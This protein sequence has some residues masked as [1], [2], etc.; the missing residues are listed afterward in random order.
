VLREY[1]TWVVGYGAMDPRGF[2]RLARIARRV[3]RTLA[4]LDAEVVRS[5]EPVAFDELDRREFRPIRPGQPFGRTLECAWLRITGEVPADAPADAVLLLG[6]RGEGLVHD[7]RGTV[8]DAVSTVFQQGDL[9]HSGGRFRPVR[10][11]P[12]EGRIELYADV[13]Y[14]GWLLYPWGRGVFHGAR[15]AVRDDEVF[16]LYYDYLTLLVLAGATDDGALRRE[17]RTALD[18]AWRRFARGDAVAARAELAGPLAARS[19]SDLTYSAIG[20]GHLDM[21]WLWPLRETRRKAAR[22]YARQLNNVAERPGFVYGTSQPQQLAWMKAEQ[23]AIYERLRAAVRDRRIELQ[24]SFWVESDT[25]LPGGEALVRQALVGRRFLQEEF[26]LGDDE[27]RLCWL[28]DSFG[29][30]GALPQILRGAGMD[31]MQTIKIAWNTENVFPH[32]T[33]HWRGIDGTD[34]LVH[35][36]PEGDYN[37]RGA[38]DGLLRGLAKYPERALGRALLVFGSGDGGGGPGEIHLEVTEREHDLRGI[39]RVAY[40]PAADFFRELEQLDGVRDGAGATHDGELYLERHQGTYTTQAQTKRHNRLVERKLHEVEALAAIA[41]PAAGQPPT[42]ERLEPHWR[43]V[44]LHQFHD[45]LPGSAIERVNRE[46]REMYARVEG[47]LDALADE[48]AARL[49]RDGDAPSVVNLTSFARTEHVRHDGAWF[50]AEVGPYAAAALLPAG[51]AFPELHH[52]A[53]TIS[54]G[55]VTLRFGASGEIVSC[56]DAAGGEHARDGL[57]RLVL[58]RDPFQW[59][60]D[61]WDIGR[62]Y[63]RRTPDLLVPRT[64]EHGVDGPTVWRRHVFRWRRGLVEQRIVLEADD[65]LVRIETSVDWREDHR[66]LRADFRPAHYGDAARCE[67]QFGHI[68]RSTREA[69]PVERA[70]FEVCAHK[71][72]S[73]DDGEAAFAVLNDAKYGHRAKAGLLSLNLLRAPTFPDKTADRG[74]HRFTYGFRV[75]A[76]GAEG[77]RDIVEDGYR[78]NN[79]LRPEAGTAFPSAVATS[80]PGVVIETLKPA[81]SGDGVVVRLYESLGRAT[82]TALRVG[83]P[84]GAATRTD[85]LERPIAG[86]GPL[87]LERLKLHPFEIVTIHL[88]RALE[89]GA[90][91]ISGLRRDASADRRPG[92]R[93]A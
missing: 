46:A 11:V 50:R 88:E 41:G 67:I 29:Y 66:M 10:G 78:L 33:F 75:A 4:P 51:D 30:S 9:P 93:T 37:S 13:A 35:M 86:D 83:I 27:L 47:G 7:A 90:K 79:P 36:P 18:A 2:R 3:Y 64:V 19:D 74:E 44:L 91:A 72:I 48:L 56:L 52:D 53:D 24:G 68:A 49:P 39:P 20:H 81:E 76:S 89:L 34:V 55:R 22:T 32:R 92:G 25:N 87:D 84:H 71:W 80:D 73:V 14:N 28:P 82:T 77:L 58:H 15:I 70:Q 59:P 12:M 40:S 61:A 26:G 62:G 60:Y 5:P 69:D 43:D 31:W 1:A 45:I 65:D 17:L 6:I 54:N 42:R 63:L 38:A 16:G 57:N 21:A 8:L 85:L 23:P